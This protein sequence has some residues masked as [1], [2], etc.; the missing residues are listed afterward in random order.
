MSKLFSTLETVRLV[1]EHPKVLFDVIRRMDQSGERFIRESDLAFQVLSYTGHMDRTT[2]DRLRKV[3]KTDNLV[4]SNVVADVDN[5][6]GERRLFFQESLI[7]LLRICDASLHQELTDARLRKQLVTLWGIQKDLE[8]STFSLEDP[9]FTEL[10]DVLME[11]TSQ[12]IGLLRSNVARMSRISADL[13]KMSAEAS[14]SPDKFAAFREDLLRD[15]AHLYE[16][17]IKPTLR[18]LNPQSRYK[19]G[20]NLFETLDALKSLL[21]RNQHV[22]IADQ[23]FRSALSLGAAFQPIQDVAREVDHFL[24]KTRRGMM[25]YNA[26]EWHYRALLQ[27]YARTQENDLRVTRLDGREFLSRRPFVIG[28]RQHSRPKEYRFGTSTSY[29]LNLFSEIECRLLD[30]RSARQSVLAVTGEGGRLQSATD[31]QR[32][33]RLLEILDQMKFRATADLT[34]ELHG[35]LEGLVEDYRFT[36]LLTAMVRLTQKSFGEFDLTTTNRF[37]RLEHGNEIF[38]YRQRRLREKDQPKRELTDEQR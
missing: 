20:P 14:E 9:D 30:L 15:V 38:V 34:Q 8:S 3:F 13:Q 7:N 23:V 27:A 19:E 22:R 21:D 17:H 5:C 33:T 18:F 28:L 10:V 11:H 35:R 25:Q 29:Y 12:L 37:G 26:M 32:A 1:L 6:N 4:K 24:R 16:R 36:D 31:V 2:K